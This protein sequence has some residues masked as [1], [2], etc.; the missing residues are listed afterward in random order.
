VHARGN[1]L[2]LS[3]ELEGAALLR[4]LNGIAPDILFTACVA[5]PPEFRPRQASERWYRYFEPLDGRRVESWT[6]A[7]ELFSGAVDVRSLGRDIP[8]DRPA[9]RPVEKVVVAARPPWIVVDVRARSF[10][11]GM[12]RRMISAMRAVDEGALSLPDLKAA[13][14]GGRR[15]A[16]PLAEPDRLVLW[17]VHYPLAWETR[18]R[19]LSQ[20]QRAYWEQQ[21]RR[22]QM[23]SQLSTLVTETA[24]GPAGEALAPLQGMLTET[25]PLM[26]LLP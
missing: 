7:A 2:V 8:G 17:E 4:A 5:V 1:A 16:L 19:T 24:G 26:P 13:L 25:D 14:A 21:T 20:R 15:L 12:V 11:W 6:R 3:S 10:V 18:A 9:W 22:A 23:R